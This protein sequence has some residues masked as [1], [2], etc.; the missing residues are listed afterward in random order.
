MRLDRLVSLGVV[1]PMKRIGPRRTGKCLPVLMYHSIADDGNPGAS[2]Y[3][4]LCTSVARFARQMQWLEDLGYQGVTLSEGLERLRADHPPARL[5]VAITFDDGFHDFYTAAAPI[6]LHHGFSATMYLPAAF[7]GGVRRYLH[8]QAC[9]VWTEVQEL[10]RAGFEF[11]SH[12][13]NHP[14]LYRLGWDRI[15]DELAASRAMI[16]QQLGA[17]VALFA[18][19]Y[20]F[21]QADV[22]FKRRFS[23]TLASCGYRSNATTIIGRV[24][25][26]QDPFFLPRLPVNEGDDLPFLRAKL[27]GAYDWLSI[28]QSLAKRARNLLTASRPRPASGKPALTPLP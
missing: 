25:P 28:P 12:T 14:V 3:F 6:L 8:G 17:A 13:M 9:M 22:T 20:A 23:E 15:A 16:E 24:V 5:P 10:C 19:P 26:G 2:S 21:P 4:G 7:I 11:G 27:A 1:A 18:Y